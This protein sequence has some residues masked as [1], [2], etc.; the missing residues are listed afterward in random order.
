M[1]S[2]QHPPCCDSNGAIFV[3]GSE[4]RVRCFRVANVEPQRAAVRLVH[5]QR[6]LHDE[7]VELATFVSVQFGDGHE[8][9][10]AHGTRGRG[11]A[12]QLP[13]ARATENPYL[14]TRHHDLL[15]AIKNSLKVGWGFSS[16]KRL[17]SAS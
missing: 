11:N 5:A 1:M 15:L 12:H 17:I 13:V 16:K 4:W 6:V 14:K 9:R 10:W 7:M 2:S 3:I 8:M